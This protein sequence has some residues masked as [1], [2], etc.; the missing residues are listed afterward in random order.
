MKKLLRI[1]VAIIVAVAMSNVAV[2]ESKRLTTSVW[3]KTSQYRYLQ[4]P[5]WAGDQVWDGSASSGAADV[6]WDR[7]LS[8]FIFEDNAILGFGNTSAAPDI[9][10]R[11]DATNFDILVSTAGYDLNIGTQTLGIDLIWYADVAGS[12]VTFAEETNKVVMAGRML[13]EFD[14]Q[15]APDATDHGT[16]NPPDTKGWLYCKDDGSHS[17]LYWEDEVGTVTNLTAAAGGSLDAA[18]GVGSTITVDAGAVTMTATDAADNAVLALIQQDTDIAAVTMSLTSASTGALLSFDSNGTGPDILGSDSNWTVTKAGAATFVSGVIPTL[19]VATS[20]TASSGI[21]LDSGDSF[22]NAVNT[23]F[24]FVDAGAEDLAIDMDVASNAVGLK[25][26]TGV[27]ELQFGLVDDL[28]GIGTIA[29]DA[30][31]SSIT[32]PSDGT[33]DLTIQVTGVQDTRLLLKSTGTNEDALALSTSAGGMTFTVA[34][35][36]GTEDMSFVTNTSFN[37]TTTEATQA[38]VN[39]VSSGG[40]DLT[41]S[42]TYDIALTATGGK[43]LGVATEAVVDQFKMDAQ[44]AVANSG[45]AG[46]IT[47]ETTNGGIVFI[48]D[49]AA[50]GDVLFDVESSWFLK[51]PDALDDVF[52]IYSSAGVNLIEIDLNATDQIVIGD[53]TTGLGEGA[54]G[55]NVL[56]QGSLGAASAG[57]SPGQVGGTA[58]FLGGTGGVAAT[59][60]DVGGIGGATTVQGG[61][62][63]AGDTDE[64]AAAGGAVNLLGGT[65]GAGDGTG[66]AAAGGI[67]TARGG[68]GGAATTDVDGGAGGAFTSQGGT[69]GIGAGTQTGGAGGVLN[70]TGGTAG[71][72]NGGTGG[73]GGAVNIDGGTGVVAGNVSID[74]GVG[75]TTTGNV[76]VA[77]TSGLVNSMGNASG[78]LAL[79]SS[80]WAIDATGIATNMGAFTSNGLITT[81]LGITVSGAASTIN[82]DSNFTV[83]I[84]TGTTTAAVSIGGGNNTIALNSS[85]WGITTAGVL[86]GIGDVTHDANGTI[87]YTHTANSDADDWTFLQAGGGNSSLILQG[88]GTGTDAVSLYATAG[89]ITINPPAAKSTL[90]S[91]VTAGS[92]TT[93]GNTTGDVNITSDNF[94]ITD[95]GDVHLATYKT[96]IKTISIDDDAST[97]DF[98]FDDDQT[99][100]NEQFV[101]FGA[102]IPAYAEIVAVQIRC[103][104]AVVGGTMSI[105]IG[106]TTGTDGILGAVAVDALN[107]VFGGAAG[108]A[109][110]IAVTNAARNVWINATPS[111]NWSTLSAGRYAVLVTYADYGDVFTNDG[112]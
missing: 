75:T 4:N 1:V 107:E 67:G 16:A 13:I 94:A 111:A 10:M 58:I 86:T 42:A 63:G 34:G 110:I 50:N 51:V 45:T 93:I 91:T 73:N 82:H 102:L 11:W 21:I 72:A 9:Y 54:V 108:G 60:I 48:V 103:F 79:L 7:S 68:T 99:N 62:G 95:G 78:T 12:T 39:F 90:I 23:E 100:V 31:D 98:Q 15:A 66:T 5:R 8:T 56:V 33:D 97:D 106:I 37:F 76:T 53:N 80:D 41:T 87:T 74:A 43:I 32:L 69:G 71:A 17:A 47:F 3:N 18:Y 24:R 29:F 88:S 112:P 83:G 70:L 6:N 105:D 36:A 27:D 61:T 101:D 77:A 92:S 40:F 65:G 14:E 46:A 109:P 84:G 89:D 2:A 59:G 81:T 44:G 55:V 20:L 38:A 19:T 22:H 35:A 28:T 64:N 25:S 57:A 52:R 104:E 26:Y 49:G 30:E 96:V 85:D